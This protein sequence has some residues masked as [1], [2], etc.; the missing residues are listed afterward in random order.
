M[1][2]DLGLMPALEWQAREVSRRSGVKIAVAADNVSDSLPDE[3]RTCIYRVAQEALQNVFRHS[4]AKSAVVTVRQDAGSLV[5][6]VE[7]DGS[8]FDPEKTRGLGMLGMEERVRQLGGR[9][10]V[11][12]ASGKGTVLKVTIPNAVAAA[13]E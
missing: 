8:G 7:D 9:L 5:L 3:M 10:E 4:G 6:S 11:Q 12:S 2:D 1:L 13:T